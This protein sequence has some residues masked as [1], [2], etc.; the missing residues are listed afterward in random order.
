MK[1]FL[2]IIILLLGISY[3]E[4]METKIIYNIQNE[5]ITNVDIKNEFKYLLALNN[6]L[7]E[8][9]KDKVLKISSNS[10]IREKI[11]KVEISKY[12]KKIEINSNYLN[13]V[14]VKNIYTSLGLKSLQ[15]FNIYLNDYDLTLDVIKKKITIDSLWNQLI[16]QKYGPQIEIDEEKI[17]KKITKNA[18]R[19]TKEYQLSE[20]LFEIK[21]KS[22]IKKKYE[23]I[24]KDINNTGFEN[25]A[26]MYSFAESSKIGGNIG[27]INEKSLNNEIKK[28]I[29]NLK[30]GEV[31]KPIILPNGI[32][33]LK[34]KNTRSSVAK[35]D[36]KLELKKAINYEKSRQLDQYSKIYFNK[37]QKNLAL[38]E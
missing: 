24:I 3:S 2:S 21:N 34:I 33:I 8:L 11:K 20:I 1:K 18:N 25:T 23:E 19:Q 6:S 26:S 35:T 27:W 29:I 38:N 31:S 17:K 13:D 4:A 7:K 30:I 28:K 22:E 36:Y 12:F 32:L 15:E 37:I 5:I 16:V 14:L 9:N 10:I